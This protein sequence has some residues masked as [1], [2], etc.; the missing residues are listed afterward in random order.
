MAKSRG[1][2]FEKNFS[3]TVKELQAQGFQ[4]DIQRLYD[5][6][7]KKTINQPSD[8]ICYYYPNEIYV[9]CKSTNDSSFSYYY[10][11]QYPRLIEKSKI[12]GIKAGMLIWFVKYKRVFWVDI[13]WMQ[14]LFNSS[15]VKSFTVNRLSDAIKYKMHGVFEVEQTSVRINPKMHL[16]SMF[17]FI[18]GD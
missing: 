10:Q 13:D 11:P 6:V 7:G 8:F 9:E 14:G 15:G 2:E 3:D 1:K 16:E 17:E 4:V 18:V 5:V 12:R